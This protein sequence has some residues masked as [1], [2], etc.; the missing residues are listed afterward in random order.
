LV[1]VHGGNVQPAGQLDGKLLL[2]NV[3][4]PAIWG[5][6]GDL[7][8]LNSASPQLRHKASGSYGLVDVANGKPAWLFFAAR[9]PPEE[10]VR[11]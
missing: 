7:R 3:E 6:H 9:D 2:Q 1:R 10:Q 4:L 11:I 5:E 8:K